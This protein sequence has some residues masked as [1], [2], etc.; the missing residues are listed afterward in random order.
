MAH[1]KCMIPL[2]YKHQ[3][4]I[5]QCFLLRQEE[6]EGF[7]S[8]NLIHTS[9]MVWSCVSQKW[10]D[11]L[12]MTSTLIV[13]HKQLSKCFQSRVGNL[14]HTVLVY[15]YNTLNSTDKIQFA[16][17][18]WSCPAEVLPSCSCCLPSIWWVIPHQSLFWQCFIL[19]VHHFWFLWKGSREKKEVYWDCVQMLH[20]HGNSFFT[21][22]SSSVTASRL[23]MKT[24]AYC[25]CITLYVGQ[26]E[27]NIIC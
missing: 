3:D 24:L 13:Y 26:W 16:I 8:R 1:R 11:L 19:Q 10:H 6:S 27:K 5:N 7:R 4:Q 14:S 22:L 12:H 18:V 20:F 17:M 23:N 2:I 21:Q 25:R 9:R 15:T